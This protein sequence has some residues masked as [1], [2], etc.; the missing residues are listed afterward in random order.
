MSPRDKICV[1]GLCDN[2]MFAV[3]REVICSTVLMSFVLLLLLKFI[4]EN[5]TRMKTC[6]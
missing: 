5:S 3:P 6:R 4:L 2:A 1:Y